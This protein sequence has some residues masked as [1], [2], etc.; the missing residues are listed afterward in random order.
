MNLM[1]D[2]LELIFYPKQGRDPYL[3]SLELSVYST[4]TILVT[5]GAV[6]F[7]SSG[8]EIGMLSILATLQLK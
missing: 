1:S 2:Q 7:M 8:L 4:V 6:S 5:T 3:L